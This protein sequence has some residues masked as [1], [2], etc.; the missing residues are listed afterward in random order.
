MKAK[1]LTTISLFTYQLG[2]SQTE[3]LLK[4][5]VTSETILLK[6]VEV[7]NKTSKTSTTTN[8]QGEFLILVNVKDSLIFFSNDYLFKRLKITQENIEMNNL[9][10]KMLPKPEE[11]KE[12]LILSKNPKSV[13]ITKEEIKEIKLNKSRAKLG[14]KIDGYKDGTAPIDLGTDF[15][16]L[17]KQIY[18]IFKKEKERKIETPEIDF[19]QLVKTTL[20][21]DFFTK[22]LKLNPEEKELFLTFCDADPRS[23]NLLEHNNILTT[24]DFLYAKNE[25]FKKMKAESKN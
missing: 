19:I 22:D 11:L 2:V 1:L 13:F 16:R 23:K 25:S 20:N 15:V 6:N 24:M 5:K 18:N 17:G 12:V 9:T 8:E 10:V 3:K 4:G 14:M 7:I 21:P